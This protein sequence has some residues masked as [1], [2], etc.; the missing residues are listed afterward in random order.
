MYCIAFQ[1]MDQHSTAFEFNETFLIE[2]LDM[3]LAN[4]F[5]TFLFNCSRCPYL[6]WFLF[7]NFLTPQFFLTSLSS[8]IIPLPLPVPL[9]C[10][11]FRLPFLFSSLTRERKRQRV[12]AQTESV[13]T[14]LLSPSLRPSSPQ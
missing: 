5:G 6:V 2:L 8:F 4:V 9:F 7:S 10:P 3:M 14:Y 12:S 13:W 1:V 11:F